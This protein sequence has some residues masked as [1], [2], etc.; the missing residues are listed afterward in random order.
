MRFDGGADF[1]QHGFG[2]GEEGLVEQCQ[3]D[4]H[5]AFV[6]GEKVRDGFAGDAKCFV[7]GIAVDTGGDQGKGEALAA[8]LGGKVQGV[9]GCDGVPLRCFRLGTRPAV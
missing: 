8:V 1:R 9:G 5:V 3:E 6:G 7:F 4:F 2:E